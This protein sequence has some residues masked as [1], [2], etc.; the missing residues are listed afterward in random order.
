VQ[1]AGAAVFVGADQGQDL[2]AVRLRFGGD[3]RAVVEAVDLDGVPGPEILD[4]VVVA[5]G[6]GEVVAVDTAG[7]GEQGGDRC[8]NRR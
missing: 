8:R 3:D 6:V 1:E 5:T 4:C 2:I 7:V